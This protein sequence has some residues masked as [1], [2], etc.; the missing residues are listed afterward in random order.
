MMKKILAFVLTL[1]VMLCAGIALADDADITVQGT[2]V[3]SANP[4]MVSVTANASVNGKT[5]AS[6]Q[7]EIS[8][9]IESVTTKLIELGVEEED[10][11]TQNYGY[12]PTYN[13]ES[14]TRTLTGYQANHT[15]RITCRDVEMLDSVIGVVT[16]SGMSEIYDVSYD[17]STRSELYQQALAMAIEAAKAKA[18]KMAQASGM[19][20][21]GLDSLTENPSYAGAYEVNSTADTAKAA[22][23]SAGTGIRAGGVSVTASVTAVYEARK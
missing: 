13:Y 20:L 2:A 5:V 12:Y 11:I 1:A 15:L 7:E 21:T 23:G 14:D 6:A 19:T 10:I 16:D 17:V 22:A 4:D 3:I 8:K 18:E 9:I